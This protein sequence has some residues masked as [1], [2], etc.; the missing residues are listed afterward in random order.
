M[1]ILS[2]STPFPFDILYQIVPLIE[3]PTLKNFS[4]VNRDIRHV[5]VRRL[6][7]SLCIGPPVVIG[8]PE[9]AHRR[10]EC[11]ASLV[12]LYQALRRDPRRGEYIHHLTLRLSGLVGSIQGDDSQ[13]ISSPMDIVGGSEEDN[14]P[15]C[16]VFEEVLRSVTNIVS[17][18]I[19]TDRM[20]LPFDGRPIAS[21]CLSKSDFPFTLSSF[22]TNAHSRYLV[23][24]L[25]SQPEIRTYKS[26]PRYHPTW[27]EK[28]PETCLPL[29]E[30]FAGDIEDVKAFVPG[31]P[32][33]DV[34]ILRHSFFEVDFD[35][36]VNTLPRSTV[37]IT[38]LHLPE[39]GEDHPARFLHEL[40]DNTPNLTHLGLRLDNRSL[41]PFAPEWQEDLIPTFR[42][43]PHLEVLKLES[44][45]KIDWEETWQ[46]RFLVECYSL[47]ALKRIELSV[48]G[49][50]DSVVYR[51]ERVTDAWL[52]E[53]GN[54]KDLEHI[55]QYVL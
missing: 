40:R 1:Q 47:P 25:I 28:I 14:K 42:D 26:E 6:W 20:H 12:C 10:K 50:P 53:S 44:S 21:V 9:S 15:L 5:C 4:A 13:I 7:Q 31:R 52:V 35:D 2:P 39:F 11:D 33:H 32:I 37:P 30:S 16:D 55:A 24:F 46:P 18:S 48:D 29:L 41:D 3:F 36:V 23:P 8:E 45:S 22:E 27:L 49:T 34:E 51:R 43:F 19:T 38:R 17:L 54:T